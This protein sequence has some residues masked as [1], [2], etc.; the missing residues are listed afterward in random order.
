[1]FEVVVSSVGACAGLF[2]AVAILLRDRARSFESLYLAA[3]VCLLAVNLAED[4]LSAAR[5]YDAA[6]ALFGWSYPSLVLIGPMVWL[7]VAAVADP[8]AAGA[9]AKLHLGGASALL[10]LLAPWLLS[11]GDLRWRIETGLAAPT[12]ATAWAMGALVLFLT[13]GAIQLG[14]Y[15]IAA[16]R[17]AQAIVALRKRRWTLIMTATAT[18]TWVLYVAALGAMMAGATAAPVLAINILL[19]A[20]IYG[21][22]TVAVA[23]P[24]D[25]LSTPS[26]DPAATTKYARSALSQDDIARLMAKLDMAIERDV[27]LD[28]TLTLHKLAQALQS[29]ANDLSQA[30]NIGSGGFHDWL[31]R[32][33]VETAMQWM[34]AGQEAP[35]FLDL[36]LA[37]G[38]N[39]KSTFYDA[40]KRITGQTPATWRS[41]MMRPS[42][43][44]EAAPARTPS[45]PP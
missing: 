28:H 27:H 2:F 25:P 21:L 5:V 8:V 18:L 22:A 38:F 24:P 37:V 12:I 15:L 13:G 1:M 44:R 16:L 3:A 39:S 35:S 11:P 6:P 45:C 36:A 7:H 20:T 17:R 42:G 31:A 40:F 30:L 32:A 14:C 43:D 10:I 34:K 9:R 23:L 41:A 33:R 29:S 19:A 4:A 26:V